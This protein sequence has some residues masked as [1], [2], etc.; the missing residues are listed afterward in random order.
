VRVI[1]VVPMLRSCFVVVVV[2]LLSLG[3][4]IE[5]VL[6]AMDDTALT[7][8]PR[9]VEDCENCIDDDGDG[10]VDRDDPDCPAPANGAKRGLTDPAAGHEVDRCGRAIQ[11]AGAKLASLHLKLVATC[12]TATATCVQTR[13]ADGAC[14]A[15]AATSCGT[16]L[17]KLAGARSVL[18]LA[19][20]DSCS[21]PDV[22]SADLLGATGLGFG[23]ET[24]PCRNR[25]TT[26]LT[27][28]GDVSTCV[29][30]QQECVADRVIGATVP[31]AAELLALAGRD[32]ASEFPCLAIGANGGGTGIADAKG[33][34]LRRCDDAIHRASAKLVDARVTALQSCSAAVFSCVQ[35][36]GTAAGCSADAQPRCARTFTKLAAFDA[37]LTDA[38]ARSCT[39]GLDVTDLTSS[40]G[41]GFGALAGRCAAFGVPSLGSA[42]DVASCIVRD[43]QCRTRQLVESESPRLSELL[44][45]AV[46]TPAP[47]ATFAT[48]SRTRTPT[49]T[50]TPSTAVRTATPTHTATATSTATITRTATATRTATPIRT[51]TATTAVRTATP[52][53]TTPA[54]TPTPGPTSTTPAGFWD[55]SNIPAAQNVMMFKFMNRTNGQYDDAHVFWQVSIGGV[56]TTH[57][58]AEQ[59]LFDMPA[60]SS[61]RIYI[62][63][64][65]VGQT[66]TDYYDFLEYTIGPTRFNGN[67]TRVDAFGIKVAMRLHNADGSEQTVGENPATFAEDRATTFQRFLNAVPAEFQPLAQLQAPYRILNPGAGGFDSGGAQQDYYKA[68]IDQIWATDHLTIPKAGSNASGLGSY[69]NLSAAIYRHTWHA[70]AFD[71]SGK[72]LDTTMWNDPATFYLQA[73]ADYYAKFMHDIAING[74]AYGFPYDDVGGYSSYIA[75]DNPQY[76][77]V[78]IGW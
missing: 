3:Q 24:V 35:T 18:D 54:R 19:L 8:A 28:I 61:G 15:A 74:K 58:I 65:K 67:T 5:A 23:S 72:L 6:P 37:A 34:A 51:A 76:M 22:S 44:A 27:S 32:V 66:P 49:P 45:T 38:V 9:A 64:G 14:L 68:Y 36:R 70:G 21:P 43:L 55:A 4:R 59:P 40:Q 57:S 47:T 10:L 75:H 50:A 13:P 77:L 25:G 7:T 63:L 29:E 52:T 31:R 78:A 53:P 71:T 39:G 42:S 30:R 46:P 12:L 69:P 16:R 20:Q 48:P 1:Q 17:D 26:T 2:V 33:R 73:P 41:L 62:Y 56:K 60:N 11:R